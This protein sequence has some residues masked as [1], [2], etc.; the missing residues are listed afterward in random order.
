VL[1]TGNHSEPDRHL[2]VEPKEVDRGVVEVLSNE[3]DQQNEEDAGHEP[4][5]YTTDPRSPH[6]AASVQARTGRRPQPVPRI[7]SCSGAPNAN[8]YGRRD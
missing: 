8:P 2:A 6:L 7:V 3:D 1:P 5:P 4:D